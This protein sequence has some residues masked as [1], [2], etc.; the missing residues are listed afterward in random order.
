MSSVDSGF[1]A[2]ERIRGRYDSCSEVGAGELVHDCIEAIGALGVRSARRWACKA[3]FGWWI[4]VR[5]SGCKSCTSCKVAS[6][7]NARPCIGA[8]RSSGLEGNFAQNWRFLLTNYYVLWADKRDLKVTSWGCWYLIRERC[9]INRFRGDVI[10]FGIQ[11]IASSFSESAQIENPSL[12]SS[13]HSPR[14]T[15]TYS[16]SYI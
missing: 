12:S 15:A 8:R 10:I 1:N 11:Q 3:W 16:S 7:S 13:D 4:I 5:G 14:S 6:R 9:K 2:S